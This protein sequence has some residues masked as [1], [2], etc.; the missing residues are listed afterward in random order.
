MKEQR[1]YA[2]LEVKLPLSFT[3][4]GPGATLKGQGS[5]KNISA[6]GLCFTS[7]ASLGVGE[8]ISGHLRLPSG[9]P[10]VFE[11]RI[12]W[13]QSVNA[14]LQDIGVEITTISLEDQN[15]YLLFVCGLMYD[16]LQ[17]LQLI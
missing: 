4:Q 12:K 8:K 15:R 14:T 6:Y 7:S 5:T 9:E 2:R 11:G 17:N 10:I 16:R 1:R 3:R 13:I